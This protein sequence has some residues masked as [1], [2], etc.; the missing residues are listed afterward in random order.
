MENEKY[1]QFNTFIHLLIFANN[2]HSA[3]YSFVFK[4]F[5]VFEKSNQSKNNIN[6][7][8]FEGIMYS[9]W[10]ILLYVY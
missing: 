9:C 1:P 6:N 2:L 7:I 10:R 8:T 5:N 4:M 3:V